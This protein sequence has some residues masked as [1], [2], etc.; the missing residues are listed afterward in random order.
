MIAV[1][2]VLVLGAL[3][4]YTYTPG[5]RPPF[6][7]EPFTSVNAPSQISQTPT[8]LTLAGSG[9]NLPLTR[10]LF[11][12]FLRTHTSCVGCKVHRSIGS[13]G[14]IRAVN[15]GA[16]GLGLISRALR[17]NERALGLQTFLY[18]RVS[19][20]FAAHP[21]VPLKAL[22]RASLL[23]LYGGRTKRWSNGLPVV[24]F[25][26]EKGDS[27]HRLL[28]RGIPGFARVNRAAYR[29]G[30]WR[31]MYRDQDMQEAL[32]YT[33]GAIGVFDKG[34]IVSQSLPLRIFPLAKDVSAHLHKKNA[35]YKPLSF[36]SRVQ[37]SGRAKEFLDFTYSPEGQKLICRAGYIA[38]SQ[39]GEEGCR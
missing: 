15:D 33:P 34:A 32:M 25:Q 23:S 19:V 28:E 27:G 29:R 39:D 5:W 24:V 38:I 17:A 30:L 22:D 6:A 1:G 4:I 37:P 8:T 36:V 35:L 31:V 21:S 3:A 13:K 14:G 12:R 9:S 2:V 7:Q 26:R 16:V 10:L 20:V 18:A 11:R